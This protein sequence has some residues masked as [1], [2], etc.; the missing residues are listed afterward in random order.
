MDMNMMKYKNMNVRELRVELAERKLQGTGLE[1]K[2]QCLRRLLEDDKRLLMEETSRPA[3]K[4][5]LQKGTFNL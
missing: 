2:E 4:K 3:P 1:T 5:Q